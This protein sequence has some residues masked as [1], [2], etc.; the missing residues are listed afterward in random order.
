MGQSALP[1]TVGVDGRRYGTRTD[2]SV[3]LPAATVRIHIR[4]GFGC[5]N[6][7]SGLDRRLGDPDAIE[8]LAKAW[9]AR[10]VSVR[11]L[12]VDYAFH[13]A[14][15]EACQSSLAARSGPNLDEPAGCDADL[16]RDRQ[17]SD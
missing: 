9:E 3:A 2:A 1:F 4:I 16:D 5:R 10:G 8:Q 17:T 14:Q 6:Q 11:M 12:P 15:M 7:C 13:S